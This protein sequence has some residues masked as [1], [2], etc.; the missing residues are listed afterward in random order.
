MAERRKLTRAGLKE[1]EERLKYLQE[2]YLPE[3]QKQLSEARKQGDL[4]ENADYDAAKTEAEKIAREIDAIQDLLNN[5]EV[6]E[7]DE[8]KRNTIDFGATVS[9]KRLNTGKEEQ[10]TIVGTDEVKPFEHQISLESP[11]GRALKDHK[12]GD[13]VEVEAPTPYKVEVVSIKGSDK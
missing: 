1:K 2:V 5:V 9:I 13:V 6:V 4:S 10:Y 7:Y 3:I 12:V 8:K 11:L